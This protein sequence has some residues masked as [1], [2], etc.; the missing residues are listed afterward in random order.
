MG[1]VD[2]QHL[3]AVAAGYDLGH[4]GGGR[5]ERRDRAV[6]SSLP[7]GSISDLQIPFDH[8]RHDSPEPPKKS[9]AASLSPTAACTSTC[10]FGSRNQWRPPC[11]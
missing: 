4:I 9:A 2:R 11:E 7:T 5:R 10:R 8:H 6:S 1:S 3:A